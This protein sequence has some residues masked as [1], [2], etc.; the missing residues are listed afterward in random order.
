M[1]PDEPHI[2]EVPLSEGA[3]HLHA[4]IS[5]LSPSSFIMTVSIP[6]LSHTPV[7]ALV[8]CGASENFIDTV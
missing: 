3:V 1:T 7:S 5:S 6:L 2:T 8:N 4:T